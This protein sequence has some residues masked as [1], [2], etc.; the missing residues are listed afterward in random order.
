LELLAEPNEFAV[1]DFDPAVFRLEG[2]RSLLNVESLLLYLV[3]VVRERET[4]SGFEFLYLETEIL[5]HS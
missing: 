3:A 1:P 4:V 5:I 2:G